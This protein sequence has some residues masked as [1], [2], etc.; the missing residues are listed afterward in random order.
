MGTRDCGHITASSTPSIGEAGRTGDWRVSH[1]EINYDLCTPSKIKRPACFL[2]WV[3]CPDGVIS[4]TVPP[5][6]DLEYCKGCEICVEECPVGAITMV[7][8]HK[9]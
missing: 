9:D 2:C 8:D 5:K 1:P 6:I 7:P 4:K 3:Y